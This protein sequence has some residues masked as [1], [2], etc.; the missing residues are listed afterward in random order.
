MIK[1]W[2]S[3]GFG[4]ANFF[5]LHFSLNLEKYLS[6]I[7][8]TSISKQPGVLTGCPYCRVIN[9]LNHVLWCFSNYGIECWQAVQPNCSCAV[10]HVGCLRTRRNLWPVKVFFF[11][12]TFTKSMQ[13]FFCIIDTGN[14]IVWP[15]WRINQLSQIQE[16]KLCLCALWWIVTPSGVYP[17]SYPES[18]GIGSMHTVT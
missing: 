7:F 9:L 12:F 13:T 18:P 1:F 17:A 8:S 10:G 5:Y 6:T 15:C 2:F 14:Q 3:F 4:V 11:S 16:S